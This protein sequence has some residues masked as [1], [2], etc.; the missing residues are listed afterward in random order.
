M[1]A[2]VPVEK[3][4]NGHIAVSADGSSWIWAPDRSTAFLTRDK[5][6]SW[7]SCQ[8]L[9]ENIRVIA[10]K[11]NPKR[12]YA[13]D[14]VA[15]LLYSS[16][17]GGLLSS[18]DTLQLAVKTLRRGN[19]S[20]TNRR[21]DP[22]GGQDRIYSTPGREGIRGLPLTMACTIPLPVRDLIFVRWTKSVL[23]MPSGLARQSR[24]VTIRPFI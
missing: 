15:G 21:G 5:G 9:P 23:S 19:A 3:A 10:D 13:V 4:R 14:A 1:C 20:L 16:E 6:N 18:T 11:V 24:A 22:R 17:D 2:T 8:G 7:M 12:F